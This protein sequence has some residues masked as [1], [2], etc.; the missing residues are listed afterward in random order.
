MLVTSAERL[1]PTHPSSV[2]AFEGWLAEAR[3]VVRAES[4]LR[5]QLEPLRERGRPAPARLERSPTPEVSLR[6]ELTHLRNLVGLM[7]REL[8]GATGSK[9]DGLRWASTHFGARA[10]RIEAEL[11]WGEPWVFDD[12]RDQERHDR[13]DRALDSIDALTRPGGAI[14][15]VEARREAAASLAQRSVTQERAAWERARASI[16]DPE[17]CPAY[18]GAGIAPQLGLVPLGLDPDSGLWEFWHV[19]SGARPERDASG[20]WSI[21]PSTGMVLVLVPAGTVLLGA[22]STDRGAPHFDP[23][24]KPSEGPPRT[25]EL[26]AF[27]LSKYEMTQAQWLRATGELPSENFVGL[28]AKP[29][30]NPPIGPTHPV[31]HVSWNDAQRALARWNLA[32][33]TEAQWEY[34][35]RA[36][37][38]TRYWSGDGF[39][40]LRDKVNYNDGFSR[41]LSTTR[42]ESLE[43]S[44]VS[45]AEYVDGFSHHAPVDAFVPNGFGLFHVLGNVAEWT[46]DWYC[47]SYSASSV[48]QVVPGTGEL[49]P[50]FSNAK[51]HRGGGHKSSPEHLRVSA[52][53]KRLPNAAAWD[54]GVRA[55]RAL[56]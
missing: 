13:L 40:S 7:E 1:G 22:Q 41:G 24:A 28:D 15:R 49:K 17:R 19:L 21:T 16:A 3:R 25:I 38:S 14:E 53:A 54:V 6:D 55:A 46:A 11:A 31:E 42:E 32:L 48:A 5:A 44:E 30:E 10:E 26:R 52:R 45:H 33:P 39:H 47:L 27:F 37:S 23:D 12:P 29:S 20:A 34:A 56:R 8:E 50:L 18:G 43:G 9:A 4:A 51:L 35:A 2:A 36:R